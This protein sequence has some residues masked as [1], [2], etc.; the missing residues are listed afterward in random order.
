MK[1]IIFIK[2]LKIIY[3]IS[4]LFINKYNNNFNVLYKVTDKSSINNFLKFNKDYFFFKKVFFYF[5]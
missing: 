3:I 5:L 4:I 2:F 1:K